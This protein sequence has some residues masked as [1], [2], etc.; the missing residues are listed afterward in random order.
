MW[1]V[2]LAGILFKMVTVKTRRG[3]NVSMYVAM[4]WLG[5]I[6]AF[7]VFQVLPAGAWVWLALEALCFTLGAA[8]YASKRLDF[9]PGVFG[10]HEVWHL[11]VIGGSLSHFLFVLNYVLPYARAA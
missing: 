11:F 3:V 7:Q 10:F 2:A 5:V 1:A 9:F 6:P 4:G 8:V